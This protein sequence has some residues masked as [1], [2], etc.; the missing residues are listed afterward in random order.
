MTEGISLGPN[1][2]YF[3]L[4]MQN[5]ILK[6]AGLYHPPELAVDIEIRR[7][8]QSKPGLKWVAMGKTSGVALFSDGVSSHLYRYRT[9]TDLRR[10]SWRARVFSESLIAALNAKL[11]DVC[12]TTFR[13][14]K[15]TILK[16]TYFFLLSESL[17]ELSR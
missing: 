8:E 7:Q 16:L 17:S 13:R 3:W 1:G 6:S 2:T 4:G 9:L 12:S 10:Q 11:I 5:G 14:L 15:L